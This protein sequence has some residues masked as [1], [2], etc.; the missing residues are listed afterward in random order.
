MLDFFSI[1]EGLAF[2]FVACGLPLKENRFNVLRSISHFIVCNRTKFMHLNIKLNRNRFIDPRRSSKQTKKISHRLHTAENCAY[3]LCMA[4][5]HL[6][7]MENSCRTAHNI[8]INFKSQHLTSQSPVK[9]QFDKSNLLC[10]LLHF[11][12]FKVSNKYRFFSLIFLFNKFYCIGRR[13][14]LAVLLYKVKRK[15]AGK[16]ICF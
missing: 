10:E 6:N 9:S 13:I 14:N 8:S 3:K 11:S 12:Y 2:V 7:V 1:I 16:R 5:Y 4:N 15:N